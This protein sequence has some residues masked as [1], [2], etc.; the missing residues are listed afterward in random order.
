MGIIGAN[1]WR[2][3][4]TANVSVKRG[5]LS[6]HGVELTALEKSKFTRIAMTVW[7]ASVPTRPRVSGW[8][9]QV[10]FELLVLQHG[11]K[12]RLALA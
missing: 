6:V 4:Q 7:G 2:G 5:N 10:E 1:I 11:E 3:I 9:V 8:S 12:L